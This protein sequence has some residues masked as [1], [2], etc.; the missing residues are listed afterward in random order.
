MG[1]LVAVLVV[2]SN[3]AI[4]LLPTVSASAASVSA[5]V[6]AVKLSPDY[7]P[8]DPALDFAATPEWTRAWR[9]RHPVLGYFCFSLALNAWILKQSSDSALAFPG[10]WTT[11]LT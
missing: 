5:T 2:A 3:F 4:P 11:E 9:K 1:A 7:L 10:T 6:S 8:P